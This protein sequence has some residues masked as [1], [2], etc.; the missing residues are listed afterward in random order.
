[1]LLFVG[2]C[3]SCARSASPMALTVCLGFELSEPLIDADPPASDVGYCRVVASSKDEVECNDSKKS[4]QSVLTHLYP[5]DYTRPTMEEALA[6]ADL[7]EKQAKMIFNVRESL[8]MKRGCLKDLFEDT[9]A[10]A[11]YTYDFGS[12]DFESNP[13]RIVNRNFAE[14]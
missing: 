4:V 5:K 8:Q 10:V 6:E 11:M 3:P 9:A 2:L 13:Y 1:M 14:M 7:T 12:K